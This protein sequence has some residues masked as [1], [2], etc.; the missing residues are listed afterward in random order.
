MCIR[1]SPLQ[2]SAGVGDGGIHIG[3]QLLIALAYLVQ[4]L[5]QI[6]TGL[7]HP[8]LRLGLHR[9][10]P[11]VGLQLDAG[12]A[13]LHLLI[14]HGRRLRLSQL[15]FRLRPVS[16]THLDVYKRQGQGHFIHTYMGDGNPL[17]SFEGEPEQ[18]AITAKTPQELADLMWASLNE[19][20]GLPSPM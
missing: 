2:L 14:G 7:L 19:G 1:D 6:L 8:F 16:Y 13:V 17:P 15:A 20:K 5:L 4:P 11:A 10:G 18:V 3:A 12:G 9:L